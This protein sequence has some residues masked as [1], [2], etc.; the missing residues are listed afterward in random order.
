MGVCGGTSQGTRQEVPLLPEVETVRTASHGVLV[1]RAA[2]ASLGDAGGAER[3]EGET[4]AW[5]TAQEVGSRWDGSN[6][7]ECSRALVC[8][9]RSTAIKRLLV[10][11]AR[12]PS[13]AVL[14]TREEEGIASV[15]EASRASRCRRP[16]GGRKGCERRMGKTEAQWR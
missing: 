4:R 16:K 14:R 5:A 2:L 1:A 3:G 9:A 13:G 8:P 10:A 7:V 6:V 12:E 11:L 15:A